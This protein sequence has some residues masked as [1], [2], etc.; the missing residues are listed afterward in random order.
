MKLKNPDNLKV[1]K[2]SLLVTVMA[3]ILGIYLWLSASES[4]W[5]GVVPETALPSQKHSIPAYTHPDHPLKTQ[6]TAPAPKSILPLEEPKKDRFSHFQLGQPHPLDSRLSYL[7]HPKAPW[8]LQV[9]LTD[10][11]LARPVSGKVSA[12]HLYV[13]TKQNLPLEELESRWKHSST[14]LKSIQVEPISNAKNRFLL[15]LNWENKPELEELK[16]KIENDKDVQ[17]VQFNPIFSASITTPA[18][19]YYNKQWGLYNPG[20]IMGNPMGKT[21]PTPTGN[22]D[23]YEVAVPLANMDMGAAA[24][25]DHSTDCRAKPIG[26][27]DTGIDFQHPELGASVD[28]TLSKN[29]VVPT[30]SA[31]DDA[32]SGHGTHVAGI[33]GAAAGPALPQKSVIGVC[34]QSKLVALKALDLNGNGLE[35]DLIKGID[36]AIET[37]IPIL[38]MSLG[39]SL[40]SKELEETFQRA[41]RASVL[42]VAAAGNSN[43]DISLFPNYPASFTFDNIISVGAINVEGKRAT[44]SNFNKTLVHMAS[45]GDFIFSTVPLATDTRDGTQDGFAV[46]SGT[47]MAAPFV[48]AA[49]SLA[50]SLLPHLPTYAVIDMLKESATEN[51]Q[52]TNSFEKGRMLK[53]DKLVQTHLFH[54]LIWPGVAKTVHLSP[55]KHTINLEFQSG[56][57]LKTSSNQVE[58]YV[59]GVKLAQGLNSAKSTLSLKQSK[60]ITL[61]GKVLQGNQILAERS[62]DVD[63]LYL[64]TQS[65]NLAADANLER[66]SVVAL[67]PFLYDANDIPERVDFTLDGELL[68]SSLNPPFAFS[69]VPEKIGL[70]H[71]ETKLFYADDTQVPL[72]SLNLN[73][74]ENLPYLPP[75]RAKVL[76][77]RFYELAAENRPVLTH[78]ALLESRSQC[79]VFCKVLAASVTHLVP[80]SQN[81]SQQ[82]FCETSSGETLELEAQ[83]CKP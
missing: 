19:S 71:L 29:F 5:D 66:N 46:K 56:N 80:G 70:I 59:D 53:L 32:L 65:L 20:P 33:I 64:P 27:I 39:S 79:Q 1:V 16:K 8:S 83:Q 31:D 17:L 67:R 14:S 4:I 41:K 82:P 11:H 60:K 2:S 68:G 42:V 34:W 22:N 25:W 72:P 54:Y 9:T 21:S 6:V 73:V 18:D 81:Y 52:I 47:S 49:A 35:S 45:P 36:Y 38:N 3:G 28:V 30:S 12:H 24:A 61:V 77:C 15:T 76:S 57:L 48:A 10:S 37:G 40:K 69:F 55:E 75:D 26:I 51:N 50:W 13:S 58:L 78:A 74:A 23:S 44:F 63:I 43:Q 62:K 7:G